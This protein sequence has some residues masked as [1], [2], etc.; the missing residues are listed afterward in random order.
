[1]EVLIHKALTLAL[2]NNTWSIEVYLLHMS[3]GY[4]RVVP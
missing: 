3:S 1:M 4:C 2:D